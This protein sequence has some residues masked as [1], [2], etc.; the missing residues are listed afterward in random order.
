M[1]WEKEKTFVIRNNLVLLP[2][3]A[4]T[5]LTKRGKQ[6]PLPLHHVFVCVDGAHFPFALR[7][8]SVESRER[9]GEPTACRIIFPFARGKKSQHTTANRGEY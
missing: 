8:S 6:L 3:G 9:K 4:R 2:N 7:P 1:H 5:S